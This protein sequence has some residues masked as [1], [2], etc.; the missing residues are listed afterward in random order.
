MLY[1]HAAFFIEK[2]DAVG[3]WLVCLAVAAVFFV[4]PTLAVL[5]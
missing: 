2:R 4:L 1:Y 3:A 5:P